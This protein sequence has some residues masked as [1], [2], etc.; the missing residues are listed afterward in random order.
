MRGVV[1]GGAGVVAE[2]IDRRH[3][4]INFDELGGVHTVA[5]RYVIARRGAV[6][7]PSLAVRQPLSL[8]AVSK[9]ARLSFLTFCV[10]RRQRKMY[11]GHARLCVCLCVCVSACP[12]PYAHTTAPIRM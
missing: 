9:N 11:C 8:H 5:A 12:R 4:S 1:W 2:T 6:P 3:M 7:R 10:S